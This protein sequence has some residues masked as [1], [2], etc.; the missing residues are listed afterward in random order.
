[1][2]RDHLGR[3]DHLYDEFITE[4]IVEPR[5]GRVVVFTSGPENIHYVE[6]LTA[7]QRYVLAFWFTCD[8]RKKFPVYLDGKA[9]V[10]FANKIRDNSR[11]GGKGERKRAADGRSSKGEHSKDRAEL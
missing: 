6:R 4:Q 2:G 9:H 8:Q 10:A 3:K 5:P 11:G 1:V 7:G